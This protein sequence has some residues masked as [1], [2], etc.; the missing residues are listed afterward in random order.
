VL[1]DEQNILRIRQMDV[2]RSDA[3]YV[4]VSGD[5]LAGA[6][7]VRTALETPV[8]GMSVR[9]TTDTGSD[10]DDKTIIASGEKD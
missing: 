7:V 8:N 4:Y 3:D 1:V 10:G 2:I 5:G 9:T 6:R